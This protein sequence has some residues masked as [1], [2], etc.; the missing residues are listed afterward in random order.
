[1]TR[2]RILE[3][4]DEHFR[5]AREAD[6]SGRSISAAV[7]MER[8]RREVENETVLHPRRAIREQAFVQA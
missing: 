7:L 6:D 8:V 3:I 5:M 2:Q 4:L 1:M